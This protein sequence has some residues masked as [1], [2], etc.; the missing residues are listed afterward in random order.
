MGNQRSDIRK[1]KFKRK[2]RGGD[3]RGTRARDIR[4]TS[5]KHATSNEITYF[6][7]SSSSARAGFRVSDWDPARAESEA[8][9]QSAV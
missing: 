2:T 5:S 8:E 1:S 7:M 6:H 9:A 3:T 4:G